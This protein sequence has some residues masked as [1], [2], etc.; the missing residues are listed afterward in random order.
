MTNQRRGSRHDCAQAVE[1]TVAGAR[2][3]GVTINISQG[4]ALVMT[5]PHPSIGERVVLHIR[6]PGVSEVCAI[7]ST[8]R[9]VKEGVGVGLQFEQL[10]PIDVWGLNK[11]ISSL[12]E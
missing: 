3:H 11:L 2:Q 10:R 6:L 9:W 8:V 1:L 4:G 12:R 7:P 5:T